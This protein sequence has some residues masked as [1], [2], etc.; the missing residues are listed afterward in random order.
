[1]I[2]YTYKQLN[3]EV[4]Q[5]REDIRKDARYKGHIIGFNP[6]F[7]IICK[8]NNLSVHITG[9]DHTTNKQFRWNVAL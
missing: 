7:E 2:R 9:F 4:K 8:D 5:A 1:M 6:G 3:D